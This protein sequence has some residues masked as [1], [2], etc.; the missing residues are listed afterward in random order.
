MGF[1]KI[2]KLCKACGEDKTIHIVNV[3]Y[4]VGLVYKT[5]RLV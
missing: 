1:F 5:A 4:C 2:D 3:S